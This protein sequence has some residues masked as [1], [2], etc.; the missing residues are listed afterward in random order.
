MARP[1]RIEYAGAVYHVMA[2]GNQ[3]QSICADDGDR[4]MWVASLR[5]AWRRTGWDI[6]AWALMGNHYHLL[7]ETPEPNL[8]L[9]MKWLQ[10]AYTQRYNARHHKRGHLFQGRY[11]AVPVEAESAEYFQTVST[12]I[13]LNPARAK[14]IQIGEQKL[15][16][17]P[18]SSYP[19]YV[20]R[21]PPEWLVTRRVLGSVGL[22]PGA[23][24][25]YEAYLETRV[26]ELGMK[27]GRREMEAAWKC[28][29]RGW[30]VGGEGFGAGLL[31]RV[32]AALRSKRRESNMGS[33]RMAHDQAQAGRMLEAGMK[34]LG[35]TGAD[36]KKGPNGQTEKQVLAWWL[37]G[38]TTVT[39]RWLAET[40]RMGYETRISQAVSWVESNRTQAVAAMRNK[41]TE[42]DL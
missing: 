35:L 5:D 14:L 22:G 10:G 7:V 32:K 18:W 36:L 21:T 15:W 17:Y 6:H 24:Q 29:R 9:G 2:R 39:R 28:L 34:L 38:R 12:Y 27:A 41:L 25:G 23:R 37:Y 11:R 8:V 26:L 31:A 16:E 13:H 3:G 4:K 40:L 30:Y 19:S 1:L 33:A 42:T 20:R